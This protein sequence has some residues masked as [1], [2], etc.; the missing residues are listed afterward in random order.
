MAADIKYISNF[1]NTDGVEGPRVT[2]G[3][4]P[5]WIAGTGHTKSAN[6]KGLSSQNPERYEAMGASGVTIAT[7]CDMGQT[8]IPTLRGY[9]VS[10]ALISH[11]ST[12][13][14][15]KKADAIK[16]LSHFPLH[17]SAEEAEELDNAIHAGYLRRYV[18]PAY[19]NASPVAFDN[20]PRQ[21][22]AVVFSLCFQLGCGGTRRNAPKTWSYLIHQQWRNASHELIHGFA[23][24]KLRRSI[25]GRLLEELL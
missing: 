3:Y 13:I 4:I 16:M 15:L 21:A 2:V 22:Q 23:S 7:G 10:E 11:L 18:R 14:G 1:L 12:Y 20:L 8:D 19:D 25:E 24:Y 9:G 6:F 5:C 17:I